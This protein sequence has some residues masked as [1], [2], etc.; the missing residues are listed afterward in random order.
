MWPSRFPSLLS[1]CFF[2]IVFPPYPQAAVSIAIPQREVHSNSWILSFANIN[3]YLCCLGVRRVAANRLERGPGARQAV[4][5]R[6]PH[7]SFFDNYRTGIVRPTLRPCCAAFWFPGI[8]AMGLLC[9]H[10]PQVGL[11][12]R[13]ATLSSAQVSSLYFPPSTLSSCCPMGW[14]G[15]TGGCAANR[16]WYSRHYS[17]TSIGLA[18]RSPP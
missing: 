7:F 5:V 9:Q 3:S 14:G 6:L 18:R 4:F 2:D 10:A 15:H 13:H 12:P 16:A 1:G 11:S 17:G 8:S